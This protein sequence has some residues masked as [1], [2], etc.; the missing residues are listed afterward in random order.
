MV[1]GP[2]NFGVPLKLLRPRFTHPC[3]CNDRITE[4][5]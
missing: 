2:E 5:R 1:S 4:L 3:A